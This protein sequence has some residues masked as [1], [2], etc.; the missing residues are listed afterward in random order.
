MP[1]AD[2]DSAILIA[3]RIASAFDEAVLA[4]SEPG[5][6]VSMSIGV[7]HWQLTHPMNADELVR[8]A[9]EAMYAAKND[10]QQ[11]VKLSKQNNRKVA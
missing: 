2:A 6:E 7:A 8:H 5:M 10:P 3:H 9:D 11:Q 1:H 4:I